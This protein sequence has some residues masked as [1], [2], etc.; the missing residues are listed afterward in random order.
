M[1]TSNYIT[2]IKGQYKFIDLKS[3]T[4]GD[5]N[6]KLIIYLKDLRI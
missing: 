4:D 1:L 5:N 2:H 3:L 6:S